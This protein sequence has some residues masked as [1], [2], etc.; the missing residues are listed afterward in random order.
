[1]FRTD[2]VIDIH[3]YMD[4]SDQGLAVLDPANRRFIQVRFDGPELAIIR[5][6]VGSHL[7]TINGRE[8]LCVCLVA[9]LWG[10][11]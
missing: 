8:L 4:A 6:E 9:V 5:S 1:M 3:L 2:P 11:D 10:H 7:F